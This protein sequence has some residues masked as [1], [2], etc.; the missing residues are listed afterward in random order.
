MGDKLRKSIS[1]I[2]GAMNLERL[3]RLSGQGTIF[4]FY[5]VVSNRSLPHMKHL[6]AYPDESQFEKD[7]DEMLRVFTPISVESYLDREPGSGSQRE[8]L[9]SFDDGLQECH[10]FIAPLL[11]KKGI[12]AIF[13]LNNDFIDNKGLFFRYRASLLI[14]HLSKDQGALFLASKYLSA[15]PDQVSEALLK[16][17]YEKQAL[18]KALALHVG[19]DEAAYLNKNPVYMSTRQVRDLG[20]WGFHLGA[21]SMDHPEFFLMDEKEMVAGVK[22]SM[23]DIEERFHISPAAFAFPFTS[24]G[25]PERVIDGLLIDGVTDVIFGTAGLKKRGKREFVQRIPMETMDMPALRLLKAEYLYY[26]IKALLGRNN[27]FK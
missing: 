19:L 20:N 16:V 13:F 23:Q 9:L 26:L 6:Y 14:E 17:T 2:A 10:Q 5:H 1:V 22:E 11:R 25:V 12:P 21:H 18:L 24:D 27:Y 4:P 7:L 3:V 8:M 15:P